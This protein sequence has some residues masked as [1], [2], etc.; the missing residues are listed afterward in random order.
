LLRIG[1][2]QLG[3]DLV[4]R[5]GIGGGGERH[6]RHSRKTLVQHAK[7]EQVLKAA[8]RS[9]FAKIIRTDEALDQLEAKSP[10]EVARAFDF[11][12]ASL[13]RSSIYDKAIMTFLRNVN[14]LSEEQFIG[15]SDTLIALAGRDPSCRSYMIDHLIDMFS[16]YGPDL[17][18]QHIIDRYVVTAGLQSVAP[19]LREKVSELLKVAV[20]ATG[21]DPDIPT[22]QG[23][24]PLSKLIEDNR[25][26][27]LFFYSSTCDHCHKQMQ[28]LKEVH[29]AE[30]AKGLGILG[31]ALD[32]DSADFKR[33]LSERGLTWPSYSEFNGWGGKAVKA[34]QVKATPSLIVVDH[35]R[36]ILAK[37]VDAADLRRW[38][39]EHPL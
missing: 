32:T 17:P 10:M 19:A 36:R 5:D 26:T 16:T 12:D 13:L 24:V 18:L 28:P 35:E 14:A 4:A 3:H 21:P 2:A 39:D 22:P 38:L 31:I 25:I 7:L 8:P 30:R 23:I 27:V 29:A 20:G 33:N 37:P 11:G 9:Y 15:A 34:Y 1:Q 6:A